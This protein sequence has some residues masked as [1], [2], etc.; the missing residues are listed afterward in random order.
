MKKIYW[1]CRGR[2]SLALFLFGSLLFS[3]LF[4]LLLRFSPF[5]SLFP[6]LPFDSLEKKLLTIAFPASFPLAALLSAL[7]SLSFPTTL[8]PLCSSAFQRVGEGFFRCGFWWVGGGF[9]VVVVDFFL[10]CGDFV[11]VL[12]VWNGFCS[13]FIGL[14]LPLG[15]VLLGS[16]DVGC[17]GVFL[18]LAVGLGVIVQF[19][20]DWL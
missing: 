16:L 9:L 13:C 1:F 15:A 6:P 12:L 11:V 4:R 7:F 14:F 17:G 2:P 20:L 5:I 18:S 8:Y 3:L 10:F 19:R